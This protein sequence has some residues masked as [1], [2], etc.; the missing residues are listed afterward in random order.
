MEDKSTYRAEDYL[1]AKEAQKILGKTY[2]GLKNQVIAGNIRTIVP[3]GR[4]QSVYLKEDVLALQRDM[5]SWG[6]SKKT[7]IPPKIARIK[8][9]PTKFVKATIE[10]MPEAVKLAAEVFGGLNT[11]PVEKRIEWLKK[12]PDIDYLLKQNGKI[13]GYFSFAPM[14]PETIQDLLALRRYAKDLTADDILAYKPGEPVDLY[15]MAIGTKPGVDEAQKHEW[16]TILMLGARA[17]ILELGKRG[18]PIKTINAHSFTK[19][20]IKMMRRLGFTEVEPQ[21]PGL[22]DFFIDVQRSGIPFLTQYKEAL[23]QW[24]KNH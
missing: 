1:E 24:Q 16:G 2:S 5:E 19:D 4:K 8:P 3:P 11:I 14:K 10:D 18:I 9:P 22:R 21:A 15:G 17:A 6:I 23:K 13:V 12:N 20:G 7:R